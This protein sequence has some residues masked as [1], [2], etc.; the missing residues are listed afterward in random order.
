MYV[1]YIKDI[2]ITEVIDILIHT[3]KKQRIMSNDSDNYEQAF[4]DYT[5][6]THIYKTT[7]N[8]FAITSNTEKQKKNKYLIW[9]NGTGCE[10]NAPFVTKELIKEGYDIYAID[11]PNLGM[12]YYDYDSFLKYP[13]LGTLIGYL[14]C[15]IKHIDKDYNNPERV[16]YGISLGAAIAIY[17]ISIYPDVFSK[18]VVNGP[19]IDTKLNKHDFDGFLIGCLSLL[20]DFDISY[21][22]GN[23]GHLYNVALS[24]VIYDLRQ[25]GFTKDYVTGTAEYFKDNNISY[26]HDINPITLK[27]DLIVF[28]NEY[29]SSFLLLFHLKY[30]LT[31]SKINTPILILCSA[32]STKT[33]EAPVDYTKSY[34]GLPEY[35]DMVV[36]LNNIDE[37]CDK[38]FTNYK[39]VKYNNATHDVFYSFKHIRDK[40][41]QEFVNFLK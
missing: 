35:G 38:I 3:K 7:D 22:Y 23:R 8:I 18:C 4:G 30:A 6:L 13:S 14:N 16:I 25:H 11:F 5:Y 10:F 21:Y 32:K 1:H 34:Y 33:N 39:L 15:A 36:D 37:K 19:I 17:Y 27:P 28:G 26:N 2:K 24:M 12:A 29:I 40:A 20:Y 41:I 9:L 31:K